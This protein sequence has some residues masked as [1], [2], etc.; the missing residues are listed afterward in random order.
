[1]RRIAPPLHLFP[2]VF[3][4]CIGSIGNAIKVENFQFIRAAIIADALQYSALANTVNLYTLAPNLN[5]DH[6]LIYGNISKGDLRGL[7]TGQLRPKKKPGRTIY[8]QLVSLAPLGRCPF[9]GFGQSRSLDH[10]LP[11]SLHP[12]YSV[13]PQNLVPC[14]GDCNGIKNNMVAAIEDEQTIHPYYDQA[15]FFSEQWLFAQVIPGEDICISYYVAPPEHWTDANKNR[16]KHHFESYELDTRF[17]IEAANE[18]VSLISS[19][20]LL[21]TPIPANPQ[22]VAEELRR[23]F[24]SESLLHIN[25][26]KTAMYQALMTNEWFCQGGYL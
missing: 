4:T 12:I 5:P 22:I 8:D 10:Y 7:Y 25:S 26:W 1:M 11:H 15:V 24:T 19:L 20:K 16:V 9:C 3:D 17:P 18:L 23:E 6:T 13:L 14:C 2:D 21:S